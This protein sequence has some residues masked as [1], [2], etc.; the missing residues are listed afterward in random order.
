MTSRAL[1]ALAFLAPLAL[2]ACGK[3]D[4]PSGPPPHSIAT[5][6]KPDPAALTAADGLDRLKGEL[7]RVE[8][9]TASVHLETLAIAIGHFRLAYSRWPSD[10][11]ELARPDPGTGEPILKIVPRD[12]WGEAY[13]YAF[14][15]A[16]KT[17]WE[18]RSAGKDRVLRTADD[19]VRAR[20]AEPPK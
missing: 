19:V 6:E 4:E 7:D 14:L 3:R 13:R 5:T 2:A 16:A 10:L 8:A 17:D 9:Q 12:P 15:D 18:L 11:D 1:V 20:T